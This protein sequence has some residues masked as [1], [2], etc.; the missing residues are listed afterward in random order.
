MVLINQHT[1]RLP[2]VGSTDVRLVQEALFI[3]SVPGMRHTST[4]RKLS[5]E[6]RVRVAW[7]LVNR[8][9]LVALGVSSPT[10]VASWLSIGCH[11]SG[12]RWLRILLRFRAVLLQLL[13]W[14]R[15]PVDGHP[16]CD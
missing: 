8:Y 15:R 10:L 11:P 7:V 5:L 16:V 13:R 1:K 3:V 9:V 14:L 4:S 2:V 12:I 6:P